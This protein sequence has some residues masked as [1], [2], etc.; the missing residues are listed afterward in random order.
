ML[1]SIDE[2]LERLPIVPQVQPSAQPPRP[3]NP[4]PR[5]RTKGFYYV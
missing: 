1:L 3:P 5:P 2:A 4:L